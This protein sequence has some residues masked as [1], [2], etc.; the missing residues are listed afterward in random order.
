EGPHRA[1]EPAEDR[2]AHGRRVRRVRGQR[3][4]ERPGLREGEGP[5]GADGSAGRTGPRGAPARRDAPPA[6]GAGEEREVERSDPEVREEAAQA[7]RRH[8]QPLS[9]PR[10]SGLAS[11]ASPLRPRL[12][13]GRTHASQAASPLRR[14]RPRLSRNPSPLSRPAFPPNGNL[15]TLVQKSLSA[16]R[17]II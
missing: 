9:R 7:G 15:G 12:S 14:P 3:R 8:D 16:P 5:A 10:L 13:G 11:Q 17:K 1:E 2:R 6:Q 4:G